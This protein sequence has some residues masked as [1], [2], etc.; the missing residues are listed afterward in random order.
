MDQ[1]LQPVDISTLL[2]RSLFSIL[3]GGRAPE[4]HPVYLAILE[5]LYDYLIR[6]TDGSFIIYDEARDIADRV[7]LE[8]GINE[9]QVDE[10]FGDPVLESD[11]TVTN[12]GK[13]IW[14]LIRSGWLTR[15][16]SDSGDTVIG[17]PS[18]I[19]V[20]LGAWQFL[21][22]APNLEQ[23]R[24]RIVS[25]LEILQ[26]NR[27]SRREAIR[28]AD[29]Q[30]RLVIS[31]LYRL[32]ND[33]QHV[34]D[35]IAQGT[36][37]EKLVDWINAYT[38]QDSPGQAYN[39]IRQNNSP[40]RWFPEIHSTLSVL[41]EGLSEIAA[42]NLPYDATRADAL[43]IQ[44]EL[45][46]HLQN[47]ENG[48]QNLTGIVDQMDQTVSR[49][50]RAYSQ[51]VSTIL[52]EP[53]AARVLELINILITQSK[54]RPARK[55][56]IPTWRMRTLTPD[57][58]QFYRRQRRLRGKELVLPD[59]DQPS[60]EL[61]ARERAR[62]VSFLGPLEVEEYF[63]RKF[64]SRDAMT[65]E[66]LLQVETWDESLMVSH[67]LDFCGM[68]TGFAFEVVFPTGTGE[69]VSAPPVVENEYKRISNVLIR[70]RKREEGS[71]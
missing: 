5:R 18:P 29:N 2:P 46:E 67:L 44:N 24:I 48:M 26:S 61:I 40:D 57:S 55:A 22:D 1:P 42:E 16:R 15:Q 25:I 37:P 34:G 10:E 11:V 70:R 68:E 54:G 35:V 47:I 36:P 23:E 59:Q 7:I 58:I 65:V 43:R 41:R 8:K 71:S 33:L 28:F 31:N 30:I 60:P 50:V 39:D 6:H 21:R 38:Q 64:G 4:L 3:G 69:I 27:G 17:F 20:T 9:L 52:N 12:G 32:L 63:N 45:E 62:S 19:F 56:I 13:L 51:Q 53:A 66:E 49:S 14:R